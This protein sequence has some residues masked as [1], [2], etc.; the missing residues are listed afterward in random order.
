[1]KPYDLNQSYEL[2]LNQRAQKDLQNARFE[3][4]GF[5]LAI[6]GPSFMVKSAL[7]ACLVVMV[8]LVRTSHGSVRA[9]QTSVENQEN[10][11]GHQSKLTNATQRPPETR[12]LREGLG[13]Q[14]HTLDGQEEALRTRKTRCDQ[15]T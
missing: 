6:Q 12:C 13:L 2:N 5:P 1:M 7:F 8:G 14:E 3:E 15:K 10:M 4:G 11:L 9:A